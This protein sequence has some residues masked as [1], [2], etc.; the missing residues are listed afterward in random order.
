MRPA[1]MEPRTD[2]ILLDVMMPDMD[3]YEVLGHL[4]RDVRRADTPEIFLTALVS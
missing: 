1:M 4:G 2:I 3:G